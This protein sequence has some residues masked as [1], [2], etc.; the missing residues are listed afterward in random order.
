VLEADDL[1][2]QAVDALRDVFTDTDLK[3]LVF[4]ILAP[5]FTAAARWSDLVALLEHLVETREAPAT[6]R[7]HLEEI[8]RL[9]EEQIHD[10]DAAFDAR[11]RCLALDPAATDV[12]EA[13][14]AFARRAER[15][16]KLVQ[17]LQGL[18]EG[19]DD[20]DTAR[21]LR[22]QV[23][24]VLKNEIGDF[25]RAVAYDTE[26]LEAFPQDMWFLHELDELYALTDDHEALVL[27]L[28]QEIELTA[29]V[30]PRVELLFRKGELA[31]THLKDLD[32]SFEAYR[33]VLSLETTNGRAI[34][35]LRAIFEAG[36]R[37]VEVSRLLEPLYTE[38]EDWDGLL[39]V[40]VQKLA[41][42]TD[43]DERF[44]AC[45]RIGALY[46]ERKGD[47]PEAMRWLGEAFLLRP[48]D[49]GLEHRL[50]E[51]ARQGNAEAQEAG[52]LLGAAD[53]SEDDK[54]RRIELIKKAARLYEERLSDEAEAL[55]WYLA[56][57]AIDAGEP[58]AL[59]AMARLYERMQRWSELAATL[60]ER[61]GTELPDD[62]R[63]TLLLT[64]ARLHVD[65]LD[66]LDDAKATYRRV[67]EIDDHQRAALLALA[68]IYEV[69]DA[70][71]ERF[72]VI[73]ALYEVAAGDDERVGY[74]KTMA[75]LLV[76]Q[77]KRPD[78]AVRLLEEI[79]T[80][81][82]SDLDALHLLQQLLANA[83]NW[84]RL[85]EVYQAE[86]QA[87]AVDGARS[88]TVNKEIARLAFE[89]LDD[90]FQAQEAM[91]R[92]LAQ[93]PGDR[94]ALLFL[95][96]VYRE[97]AQFEKLR[98]T[99]ERLLAAP[100]DEAE[101]TTLYEELGEIFTD[102]L[103][104]P[105]S[106]IAT[107]N[108][109]LTVDE[110]SQAA[111][112]NLERL[113]R[114]EQRWTD[115]VGVL[116]KK[117]ALLEEADDLK[118]TLMEIGGA[119]LER[120]GDWEQAA[121]TFERLLDL[122]PAD[123]EAYGRLE[124]IY[125]EHGR[126]DELARLLER[127]LHVTASVDDKVQLYDRLGRIHDEKRLDRD[128]ALAAYKA[129]FGLDKTN[130]A[131][132][133][134]I[135]KIATAAER[136]EELYGIYR[137]L[138]EE[139]EEDRRVEALLKAA[140]LAADK[141]SNADDAVEL[142][143]RILTLEPENETALRSLH[144]IFSLNELWRDLARVTKKLSDVTL[145]PLEKLQFQNDVARLYEEKINDREAA[146][147]E[148]R[149]TLEIDEID[150]TALTA[151]ERIFRASGDT[152]ALIEILG[153]KSSLQ[154]EHEADIK[155]EVGALYEKK[156][157]D[158]EKAIATY[159]DV[160]SYHPQHKQALERL[161]GL[162][163]EREDW[164]N[165]VEVF[166]RLL[167]VADDPH[168]RL[169]V[170]QNLAVLQE[171]EFHSK[172]SAIEYYRKIREIEP[173]EADA[174]KN[175][176][177][178]YRELEQ[179]EDVAELYR[180]LL[181]RA[182]DA[183]EQERLHRELASFYLDKLEDLDRGIR[184]LR[185]LI[186]LCPGDDGPAEQLEAIFAREEMWED[187]VELLEALAKGEGDD[188][189]RIDL[190]YREAEI[191]R[192]KLYRPDDVVGV[193]DR[194]VAIDA[195]QTRALEMLGELY[196]ERDEVKPYL[197]R[198]AGAL[199]RVSGDLASAW[200]HTAIGVLMDEKLG[201]PDEAIEHLETA[202]TFMPDYIDA[203]EPLAEI[204]VRKERWEAAEPLLN[205]LL[206]RYEESQ[207]L[208]K[209]CQLFYRIGRAAE[210]LMDTERA[211]VFYKKAVGI[212]PAFAQAVLGLA[213]LNYKKGYLDQ[214]ERFYNEALE[215]P[216]LDVPMEE[217]IQIYKA[218]GD[219]A[220]KQGNADKAGRYL[221]QVVD[222]HPDSED[223]LQDLATFFE[224]HGDWESYIRYRRDLAALKKDPMDRVEI[225]LSIGD[226]Y[227]E[228]LGRLDA[229]I[230][231]YR[232][233]IALD[234]SGRTPFL[235]LV[236][237]Y[238][239]AQRFEEAVEVLEDMN[240]GETDA[241]RRAMTYMMA[242]E[243]YRAKLDMPLE[244][245]GFYNK[246]LDEAPTKLEAFRSIDEILTR[247]KSWKEL[248]ENYLR[249]VKRVRGRDG[250]DA[251]EF[252]LYKNLGEIYRS[253]LKSYD[254]AVS[255]YQLAAKLRPTD[256]QVHEILADLYE[257]LGKFEQSIEEHRGL[258][259]A[260][261]SR[262]ESYRTLFRLFNDAKQYDKA[263][264]M[265]GILNLLKQAT[266]QE[267]NFYRQ[268]R[269]VTLTS[270]KRPLEAIDVRENIFFQGEN[271]KIGEVF[272]IL[273]Q[274]IGPRL[275]GRELKDFNLKKKHQVDLEKQ[276]HAIHDILQAMNRYLRIPLPEIYQSKQSTGLRIA[277]VNPPAMIVG[278][279]LY[280][281]GRSSQELAYMLGKYACYF[282]PLHKM[283]A[284]YPDPLRLKVLYLAAEL[285]AAP[286]RYAGLRSE[287]VD[288][289]AKEIHQHANPSQ[290]RQLQQ[291]LEDARVAEGGQSPNLDR[292][293][294]SIEYS[295]VNLG[296][297]VCND[298]EVAATLER[299]PMLSLSALTHQD[300]IRSLVMYAISRKYETITER[301]GIQI[302]SSL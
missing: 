66:S 139:G 29:E 112:Q 229:A 64:L 56:V 265:A 243:L 170:C 43:A 146:V 75:R 99:V 51:F 213:R 260:T 68:E 8:A 130:V 257:K 289:A 248:E 148:Y 163:A 154:P 249:M 276:T 109:L 59:D 122:D 162:Y 233:V 206:R 69:E 21:A 194:I 184:E 281:G 166:E 98:D 86:L 110:R 294:M 189:D 48:Y 155:M 239:E 226:V 52:I 132:V 78:D 237:L 103:H 274:I 153:R 83:E 35:R 285:F 125:E 84:A 50:D 214:A 269:A 232:E 79:A 67:L 209:Q 169:R 288:S 150:Q 124:R 244:A 19:S 283:A 300:K 258:I 167:F 72:H 113:Y 97:N 126:F 263:W 247:A 287:A 33:D 271:T 261:P 144:E 102:Y 6:R 4:D 208:E 192:E 104:D 134:E 81:A 231:A 234:A 1:R 2:E 91:E 224:L 121:A 30:G 201:D 278:D 93:A 44:D 295:A 282:H 70:H 90:P 266:E 230:E 253:R 45:L 143:E 46:E 149:A 191:V 158:A 275:K 198:L 156:L 235:R 227:K 256:V 292:W 111:I 299:D 219:I 140:K 73:E 60:E 14:V 222:Y 25:A 24:L 20:P 82:P 284:L 279:D 240:R 262:V 255:S 95:R 77:L 159:E 151:L 74:L 273:Y 290:K 107:W 302:Q 23:A 42:V 105:G 177:R 277:D 164:K 252:M 127:K 85:V 16:E 272:Q 280:Q 225:M 173:S 236:Q 62:E 138:V 145:D 174:I 63:A 26:S 182:T 246:A 176:D 205:L 220:L 183:T 136:W 268:S 116:E 40:L 204:Y 186:D 175:L 10:V 18:I 190:L 141:L 13:L 160:L 297:T 251:V 128:A 242:A 215:H 106:A 96:K 223:V 28:E 185:A 39:F 245:I 267:A 117:L 108:K 293:L 178:L 200:I 168:E 217:K 17:T 15:L 37:R 123:D 131:I 49:L 38:S 193:L 157:S 41:D 172:E 212:Q 180:E 27:V 47:L 101:R 142:Y 3:E 32:L 264:C 53:R 152:P 133:D 129:A 181:E 270:A 179:W 286:E 137:V 165:L 118:L 36:H 9:Q 55:R 207:D 12:V 22:R 5:R 161:E 197:E 187:L 115:Y 301:L 114:E 11:S 241:E 210:N 196:R 71:E 228:K 202:L 216:E 218:L 100:V 65:R 94:E 195:S 238:V 259:V 80:L 88:A 31:E 211:L 87:A 250:M 57:H 203:I 188:A 120:L 254:Y 296:F 298:I 147:R 7:Q 54:D 291:A 89:L 76:E 221:Q 34:A 135:E 92:A 61:V 119:W 58:E 171:T 199:E